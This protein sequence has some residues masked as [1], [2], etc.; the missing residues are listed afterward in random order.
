MNKD[1]NS[2]IVSLVMSDQKN[3]RN[4]KKYQVTMSNA[5]AQSTHGLGLDAKR[6]VALAI[7]QINPKKP[8]NL[9]PVSYRV[10]ADEFAKTYGTSPKNAYKQLQDAGRSLFDAKITYIEGSGKK[11]TVNEIRWI[12]KAR[13]REGEGWIEVAF[14]DELLPHLMDLKGKFASYKLDQSHALRKSYSWRIL[15][16]MMSHKKE[17]NF[18]YTP[19]EFKKIIGAPESYRPNDLKVRIIE[20]ALREINKNSGWEVSIIY[21]KTGRRIGLLIF[22]F[23]EQ[24]QMGFFDE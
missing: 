4:L 16:L 9:N 20:P 22:D 12:T 3:H 18:K 13:Y 6:V 8:P 19:E 21:R 24:K 1:N 14:E 7:C 23:W 15:E 2:G 5:L 11:R 17:R 10:R